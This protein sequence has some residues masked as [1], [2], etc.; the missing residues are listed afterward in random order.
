MTSQRELSICLVSHN[1]C[2]AMLG[3]RSGHIGG[4][5]WQTSLTARW[6]ASHGCR[7]SMVTWDEGQGD[8]VEIDG[9]R[10]LKLC[11]RDAGVPV[12]RFVHPR[13]TSLWGALRRA[14]ADL[15]YHNCA[16]YVTGA[17]AWWCRRHQRRF[18]YS[19]ASNMDVDPCLPELRSL[20]ERILYR[21]GLRHA[22]RI[23]VQTAGQQEMLRKGFSLDSVHIPMPCAGPG[24]ADYVS[25]K[26][27]EPSV[28]RVLWVGRICQV[29][30]PDRLVEIA[31]A[32]PKWHFDL[33]GPAYGGAFAVQVLAEASKLVNITVHGPV[34]RSRMLEFYRRSA[35]LCC[36][37]EVEGF[38]NTFLEAWSHGLPVVSTFD[39]DGLIARLGLGHYSPDLPG[40]IEGCGRLLESPDGWR[41]ASDNARRYYFENHAV[42]VVLPRFEQV[43]LEALGRVP[44]AVENGS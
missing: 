29:K 4:V 40:L 42:E 34:E 5:E 41:Q 1:A 6:L 33:V 15:Y 3:G 32:C 24:N 44:A 16:E 2:G 35:C 18:V 27:P 22:N 13:W 26:G 30:R 9:V 37:S 28:I 17:V 20:R 23:I 10:M 21:Y 19:T 38:P 11:S 43:F 39:P 25:P 8:G 12:V 7:V 14:D 36:T 31:K